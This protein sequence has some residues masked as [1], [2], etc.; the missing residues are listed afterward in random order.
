MT[1]NKENQIIR[2]EVIAEG[3]QIVANLEERMCEGKPL[4]KLEVSFVQ[5]ALDVLAHGRGMDRVYFLAACTPCPDDALAI[6]D[7]P[8]SNQLRGKQAHSYKTAYRQY[9]SLLKQAY[10]LLPDSEG[11]SHPKRCSRIADEL[12][13]LGNAH[14][15]EDSMPSDEFR[16]PLVRAFLMRVAR[17]VTGRGVEIAL[18]KLSV[19]SGNN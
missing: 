4:R 11:Q 18:E 10:D 15:R 2:D 6:P 12:V 13:K 5:T 7:K 16:K 19:E 3:R 1:V 14:R 17:N 9:I 8:T